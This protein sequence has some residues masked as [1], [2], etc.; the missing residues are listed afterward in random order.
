MNTWFPPT[1]C[2][3][4]SAEWAVN[5][6]AKRS[7][8]RLI[9]EIYPA[10]ALG[11]FPP[12]WFRDHKDG[13]IDISILFNLYTAGEEPSFA[14]IEADNV[15]KSRE[16]SMKAVDAL[17]DFK[18]RVYKDVWNSELIAVGFCPNKTA[19][20]AT[21]GKQV[22]T[23]DDLK[24]MKLR[25]AGARAKDVLEVLG[26]APQQMKK[27]EVYMALKTGVVDGFNSGYGSLYQEKLFEVFDYVVLTGV[28][29]ALMDDI[30]VSARVWDP[31]PANL[32]QVVRE[33]F[34][35]FAEM[36]KQESL[37]DPSGA[38]DKELLEKAGIVCTELSPADKDKL[39]ELSL[40]IQIEWIESQGGRVTEAWDIVRP[41]V[42]Q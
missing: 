2:A 10:F 13:L 24:G 5:E 36:T 37:Q 29:P 27:S 41:I 26:A 40:K 1:H 21:K 39:R 28:S 6:V 11:F 8:G 12:T 18:K 17:V 3:Y 42:M 4:P 38:E 30:V 15:F 34:T 7:D 23:L 25:S 19:I 31:L 35:E 14:V 22:T 32:K 33:V 16:Q 9:I 20:I